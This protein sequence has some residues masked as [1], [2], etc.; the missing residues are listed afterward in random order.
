LN[1]LGGWLILVGINLMIGLV[2]TVNS[3]GSSLGVFAMYKWHALTSP[4]GMA[5]RPLW[6]PLLVGELFYEITV[7]ILDACVLILFFRKLRIFRHW[8][9]ALLVACAVFSL[10]DLWALSFLGP[11]PPKSVS[12]LF[13]NLVR[14]AVW[15]PYVL[16]SRRVKVTFVR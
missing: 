11:V 5:Y 6:A 8:F 13:Q 16:M 1:G 7:L 12:V 2:I 14:C 10:L 4:A 15:I 9:I 3:M